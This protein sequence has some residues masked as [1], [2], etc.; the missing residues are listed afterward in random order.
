MTQRQLLHEDPPQQGDS[1]RMLAVWSTPHSLQASCASGAH[2]TA[3]GQL[4]R[5][6]CPFHVTQLVWSFSR[7]IILSL[8]SM[9]FTLAEGNSQLSLLLKQPREGRG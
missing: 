9:Q 6:E 7:E 3:C 5:S 4:N 2:R 8:F 1:S